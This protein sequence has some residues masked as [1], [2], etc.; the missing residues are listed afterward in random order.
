TT[1]LRAGVA[2]TF[3]ISPG[4]T[5]SA[6]II[7]SVSL[8]TLAFLS[9]LLATLTTLPTL[10][11]LPALLR[12]LLSI[13]SHCSSPRGHLLFPNEQTAS[14]LGCSCSRGE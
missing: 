10:I 5:L 3:P 9:T 6:L 14:S 2:L 11:L 7:L 8:A 13:I 12:A 1:V 4:A